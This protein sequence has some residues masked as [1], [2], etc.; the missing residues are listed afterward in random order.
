MRRLRESVLLS[1]VLLL[2][3]SCPPVFGQS[4]AATPI[5]GVL[6][7][8]ST[9]VKT[10]QFSGFQ[11]PTRIGL[12]TPEPVVQP[13]GAGYAPGYTP[14]GD[15]PK[16]QWVRYHF[17]GTRWQWFIRK[18]G[19]YAAKSLDA[20]VESNGRVR[21]D[22]GG[23]AKLRASDDSGDRLDMYYGIASPNCQVGGVN[24]MDCN[25]L[26]NSHISLCGYPYVSFSWAL[27]QKVCVEQCDNAGEYQ[28]AGYIGIDLLNIYPWVESVNLDQPP[29]DW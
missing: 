22:F 11:E 18:P 13:F 19:C 23:F 25:Q 12:S 14:P 3:V 27:W 29:T 9:G 17:S 20:C 8:D 2:L 26:N 5:R 24:W 16:C 6:S 28:D 1:C 15:S 10:T 21:I 4:R 7:V